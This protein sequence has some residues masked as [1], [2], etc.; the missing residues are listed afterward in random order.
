MGKKT[1]KRVRGETYE[2]LLD[3]PALYP[4]T[5]YEQEDGPEFTGLLDQDGEPI[6]KTKTKHRLGYL[7]K[8]RRRRKAAVQR[9]TPKEG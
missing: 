5:V 7:A 4:L 1:R 8:G 6:I 2:D 3:S 9:K